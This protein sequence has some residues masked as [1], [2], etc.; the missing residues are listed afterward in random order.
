MR[1]AASTPNNLLATIVVISTM[2]MAIL[3]RPCHGFQQQ[4]GTVSRVA[5]SG[6][7]PSYS[8]R[9]RRADGASHLVALQ[10]NTRSFSR[11][12]SSSSDD[13]SSEK[14]RILFLGTPDVAATSLKTIYEQSQSPDSQYEVVGVVT[15]PPKRRKRRGKEIP[16][17]VGLVA[18]D[19]GIYTLCPEKARDAEFLDELENEVRPDLCITAAY[20][21]YLPKR[22]L[23]LPK[24]GTLN[25]HPSLLP[26]WRGA[27][28]VQRSLEAGDNPVGVS[29]LFTVS[30]MDAGPI[31]AQ[32]SLEIDENEQATTLLPTLFDIGTKSLIDALPKVI[33]GDIT[34]DT[35]TVQDESLVAEASMIDSSEGQLWPT[36]MSAQECHNRV[37]GF[38]MWP[39][40]FLYFQV[41][42]DESNDPVKVKVV[43][44]RVLEETAEPTN[45][46]EIGPKKK[47]GLRLVCSDGSVLEMLKV[48]PATRNVMDAKSFVNGLQGN[49]VR[50]LS[51]LDE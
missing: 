13:D 28:P 21:Q 42:D 5:R 50:W 26:R 47:D 29:V 16:S 37:R 38:S 36:K 41:G 20:G 30:K 51:G 4:L 8:L 7:S 33:K 2:A 11:L 46:I 12:Y 19:L 25:I 14:A 48:Q 40:T 17:P 24:F 22:F 1:S 43:E 9:I 32:E 39:G 23:A 15:Q 27:S 49:S 18:E 45:V 6:V 35:A 44:T 3:L 31:V 10:Y 34:M